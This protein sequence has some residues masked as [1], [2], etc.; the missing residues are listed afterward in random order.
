MGKTQRGTAANQAAASTTEE[1]KRTRKVLTPAE[2]I[3][4]AEADLAALKAK[5]N[6]K[7][8]KA[9]AAA[10]EKRNDLLI[11][12]G[13]LDEQIAE[14]NATIGVDEVDE[15]GLTNEDH[16]ALEGKD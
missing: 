12:R 3:A 5:A 6:E 8:E 11:K 7:E 16:L 13:K 9:K 15:N 1:T 4:K 2:R 14:L 10:R